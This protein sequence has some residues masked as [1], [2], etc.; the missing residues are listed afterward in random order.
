MS[1]PDSTTPHPGDSLLLASDKPVG[2]PP[3]GEAGE[4]WLQKV[5]VGMKRMTEDEEY[6]KLIAKDLS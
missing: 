6:R 4:I 5:F 2:R 3:L 1:D